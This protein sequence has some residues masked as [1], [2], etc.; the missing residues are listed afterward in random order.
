MYKLTSCVEYRVV[1]NQ[2]GVHKSTF[3]KIVYSFCK[4]M[5]SSVVYSLIKV[6]TAEEACA[7]A[8]QFEEKF[9]IP[10]DH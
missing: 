5:V 3:T 7:I 4:I 2:F 10:Q 1:A 6:P 8:R 9:N